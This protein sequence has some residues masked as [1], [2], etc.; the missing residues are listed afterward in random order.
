MKKNVQ[1]PLVFLLPENLIFASGFFKKQLQIW[2]CH[3]TTRP[4]SAVTVERRIETEGRGAQYTSCIWRCCVHV[5]IGLRGVVF[6]LY[7]GWLGSRHVC[8]DCEAR[9]GEHC[10]DKVNKL[11]AIVWSR[12]QNLQDKVDIRTFET[13]V[14]KVLVN[15]ANCQASSWGSNTRSSLLTYTTVQ[16]DFFIFKRLFWEVIRTVCSSF[17]CLQNVQKNHTMLW[18][19]CTTDADNPLRHGNTRG[20]STTFEITP[21]HNITWSI[22]HIG[23]PRSFCWR[24]CQLWP[25][26]QWWN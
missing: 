25:W 8:K 17:W 13:K 2:R 10:L 14:E 24:Q 19:M 23:D 5:Y 11:W 1:F 6:A 3:I 26:T 21:Q 22:F 12:Y 15:Q 18:K 4:E 16:C 20:W 7:G 9:E